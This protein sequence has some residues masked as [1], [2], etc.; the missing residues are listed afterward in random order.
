MELHASVFDADLGERLADDGPAETLVEG[1]RGPSCVAEEPVEADFA[2]GPGLDG[3]HEA[4]CEPVSLH[5]LVGGDLHD[6]AVAVALVAGLVG[7]EEQGAGD[8]LGAGRV[9]LFDRDEVLEAVLD[10]REL[11][12]EVVELARLKSIVFG[13]GSPLKMIG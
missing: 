10:A 4:S 8:D 13:G 12:C 3:D 2:E 1:D 6:L 9:V 11:A 5:L 7:L